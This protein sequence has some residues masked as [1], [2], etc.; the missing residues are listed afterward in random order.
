MKIRT[1]LMICGLGVTIV[2]TRLFFPFLYSGPVT[3]TSEW[4][5]LYGVNS[6][7]YGAP[8][9][10][11]DQ[12]VARDPQGAICGAFTVTTPGHYGLLPC[13][14]DDPLTP[15]DE[16]ATPGDVI[17]LTVNGIPARIVGPDMPVWTE[18]GDLKHTELSVE[19]PKTPTPSPTPDVYIRLPLILRGNPYP[20]PTATRTTTPG[21]SATPTATAGPTAT[22]TATPT[23][24][25]TPTATA[26]QTVTPTATMTVTPTHEPGLQ[27]QG[28]V[29]ITMG[30]DGLPGVTIYRRYASYTGVPVA[31]TDAQGYF[32]APFMP[33]PGDEQVSVWPEQ[34]PYN[35]TPP[36]YFWRHYHGYESVT[37]NFA[38]AWP[39]PTATATRTPGATS[40]PT[41]APTATVTP[42]P[43]PTATPTATPTPSPVPTATASSSP[44][45]TATP[46]PQPTPTATPT[47]TVT[48]TAT[49]TVPPTP[50]ATPTGCSEIIVNGGMESSTAW[51]FPVTVYSAGY[52][53]GMAH[54][55]LRSLRAGI[56]PPAPDLFAFSD[57]YQEITIPAGIRSATLRYYRYPQT[58]EAGPVANF[59]KVFG[60]DP[61]SL[62]AP[63]AY[64]AQYALVVYDG[65]FD[66][67]FWEKS[68]AAT[69]QATEISL[70]GYAGRT[71]RL[72]FGVYNDG[73]NGVTSLHVVD[74]SVVV[75]R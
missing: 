39:S 38:V 6:T 18:N 61:M 74:V 44:T 68:N 8:L 3:P 65:G 5:N 69:W 49:A 19:A 12:V 58:T 46:S 32:Q 60:G 51:F 1:A 59:D 42:S 54:T 11:G 20:V 63:A 34:A 72:Q 50:T 73:A 14:R 10:V 25:A 29:A 2:I 55:G 22:R 71:F 21:P 67:L 40:T 56:L 26:T 37:L 70:L 53:D 30:G 7:I 27:I 47:Y 35:F 31:T 16:G 28:R 17:S 64:D 52:T 4:I 41:A 33:I 57:V 15:L 48:P 9:H 24:T 43:L 45:S 62:D 75:G 66:K 36:E 23:H 13:Y